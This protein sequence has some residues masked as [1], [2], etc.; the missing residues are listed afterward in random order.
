MSSTEPWK[1]R[2]QASISPDWQAKP[3]ES[4]SSYPRTIRALGSG[5]CNSSSLAAAPLDAPFPPTGQQ[6][7]DRRWSCGLYRTGD[8]API[9]V[10]HPKIRDHDGEWI[11]RIRSDGTALAMVDAAAPPHFPASLRVSL[12]RK[13]IPASFQRS[14]LGPAL[15]TAACTAFRR[16]LPWQQNPETRPEMLWH[17]G[18]QFSL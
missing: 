18:V 14:E 9:D 12:S 13:P 17:R 8:R 6:D 11:A 3:P 15:P 2:V 4:G 7:D 5:Y 10:R 16:T 1:I